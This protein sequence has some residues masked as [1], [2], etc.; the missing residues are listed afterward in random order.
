MAALHARQA[1]EA[2]QALR[3]AAYTE[4]HGGSPAGT[5]TASKRRLCNG[6]ASTLVRSIWVMS[7]GGEEGPASLT[8]FSR[9]E[10]NGGKKAA[11]AL[12]R[13]LGGAGGAKE[14]EGRPG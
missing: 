12:G 2:I 13:H 1:L 4:A 8:L 7:G 5:R 9:R 11:Q 6:C 10:G 3:R 14:L